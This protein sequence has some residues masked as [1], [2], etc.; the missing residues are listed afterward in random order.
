ML[1][2]SVGYG[3]CS[4][5]L[6]WVVPLW[7]W[8]PGRSFSACL[9]WPILRGRLEE[10]PCV[11]QSAKV[12]SVLQLLLAFCPACW[13][14]LTLNFQLFNSGRLWF[15][16]ASSYIVTWKL[17]RAL[18][19]TSGVSSLP[20]LLSCPMFM[21]PGYSVETIVL[22]DFFFFFLSCFRW[23]QPATEVDFLWIRFFL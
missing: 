21:V 16:R 10:V 8:V 6:L 3:N 13:A 5:S 4:A 14:F 12:L 11:V 23:K 19:W 2:L 22:Y 18:R 17:F 9:Q 15:C 1:L 20:W 7:L